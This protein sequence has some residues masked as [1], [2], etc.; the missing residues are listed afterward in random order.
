M[1]LNLSRWIVLNLW[2]WD[3]KRGVRRGAST[4]GQVGGHNTA[5]NTDM[6]ARRTGADWARSSVNRPGL[7][8]PWFTS[9]RKHLSLLTI[10]T[11]TIV[12]SLPISFFWGLNPIVE[13]QKNSN[14][15]VFLGASGLKIDIPFQIRKKKYVYNRIKS[16]LGPYSLNVPWA[17]S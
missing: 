13:L 9:H 1:R 15:I 14:G 16:E 17:L 6:R 10:L 3:R 11:R 7:S 5:W 12:K 4:L 2:N 8:L